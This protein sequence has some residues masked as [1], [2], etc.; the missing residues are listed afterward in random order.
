MVVAPLAAWP[1][2]Y[3]GNLKYTLYVPLL[4][5][6]LYSRIWED[7]VQ[8]MDVWCLHILI[9]CA[10]RY[11]IYQF[12]YTYSAMLFLTR[13]RIIL[14]QGVDFKQID[15]EWNWDNFIILQA[16][17]G[18][19]ACYKFGVLENLP[20]WNSRGLLYVLL[21]HMGISE[22]LYY[23]IHRLF[24]TRYLFTHYHSLHH[25]SPVPQCYT[26]MKNYSIK[27]PLSVLCYCMFNFTS[28]FLC[29][30]AGNATFLEHLIL[31]MII[32]IPILGVT[33]MGLGSLSVIYGYVMIFDF[34][35][36]LGHSNVEV[37]PYGIFQLLPFLRYLLYTPS[38]HSLH[39]KEGDTN[40]CLFM[41][42]YDAL[43]RT[44]NTN[45]WALHK[46]IRSGGKITVPDFVFL[47]HAVD[48]TAALHVPFGL[49]GFS[50]MPFTTRLFLFPFWPIVFLAMIGM[51]LFSK[52]F[53]VSFYNLRGRLHQTWCVPRFGFQYFISYARDGINKHIEETILRADRLGIKVISL[54]ALNKN[55]TLNGGGTLFIEKHP[56]IKVRVVHG[57][58]MTAAVIIN[59]IKDD[60]KEV[61]LTGA[62]SKLG[63]VIA[64]YLCR[65]GIRV[66]VMFLH[67]IIKHRLIGGVV[68][69]LE[70][71]NHHEVGAI[72]ID[73]IDVVWRAAL[74]HGLRPV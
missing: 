47:A 28:L 72:D 71:W 14:Q 39:H 52:T 6:I 9:I 66:L 26:G 20:L 48:M 5:K 29:F 11:V 61:F 58:T 32:G 59:E 38:Y 3:L 25:A 7:D 56:D 63:R 51:W 42:L 46:K 23:C 64:L 17:L 4:A 57:N 15:K 69:S 8:N 12:W 70:G 19:M 65:R 54:A 34:L 35:R 73:K 40:F 67:L 1:W 55:E 21:L 2:E 45:S 24:H 41:P 60:V 36:C 30:V 31:S 27:S 13:T 43:G 62:T 22:P 16:F 53:L 33:V 74:K 68:H 10:L 49:R 50:S 44:L 37:V 18:F